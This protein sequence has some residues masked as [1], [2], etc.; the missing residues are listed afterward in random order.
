MSLC[1]RP[2]YRHKRLCRYVIMSLCCLCRYV[3]SVNQVL[4][5]PTRETNELGI[6]WQGTQSSNIL[7]IKVSLCKYFN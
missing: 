1:R 7:E 3:T 6:S 5:D 2:H 4:G